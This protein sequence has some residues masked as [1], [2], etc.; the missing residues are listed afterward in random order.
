MICFVKLF[1][2]TTSQKKGFIDAAMW[3]KKNTAQEDII[4]VPDKRIAFYAQRPWLEYSEDLGIP[5][6]IH[7]IVKISNPTKNPG[8]QDNDNEKYVTWVDKKKK[9]KIMIISR[10]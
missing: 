1:R 5:K 10:N 7:F 3:L 6:E 2:H 8:L 9:R 4:A